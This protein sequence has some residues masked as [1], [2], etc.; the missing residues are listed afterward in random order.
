MRLIKMSA[1]PERERKSA[2][3]KYHYFS[4]DVSMALGRQPE[5]MDL[6]KRHPF[7]LALVRIPAGATLCPYHVHS[8]QWEMYVIVSGIGK[9]RDE[10]GAT[11]VSAGD[12]FLYGPGEAHQFSNP[13]LED[14]VY[15]VI[16]DNPIGATCYYPDSKKWAVPQPQ[17]RTILKGVEADYYDGEE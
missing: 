2:K 7:D 14:F 6:L 5:S 4:K 13:G 16:A 1:V 17:E 9:V 11:D 12:A 10:K 8:A 3:G 15:Y